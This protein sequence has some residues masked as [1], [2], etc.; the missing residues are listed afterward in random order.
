MKKEDDYTFFGNEKIKKSEKKN[1]VNSVF[2]SVSSKY[3]LMNDIMS[4]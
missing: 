1:R 3:D 2:K 4:S